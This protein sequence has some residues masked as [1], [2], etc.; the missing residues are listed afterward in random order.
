M[1]NMLRKREL[2]FWAPLAFA[3]VCFA[4]FRLIFDPP[5]DDTSN[6]VLLDGETIDPMKMKS[7]VKLSTA[8]A[9][10][11]RNGKPI[12]ALESTVVTHGG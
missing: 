2:G 7:L 10:A 8:V 3:I 9:Q 4:L 12:V 11:I 1:P 5:I 6:L